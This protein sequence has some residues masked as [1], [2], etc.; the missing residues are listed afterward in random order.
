MK[1]TTKQLV[2]DAMLAAM[3]AVLGYVALDLD[4]IKI[5]FESLPV[6]L[7]ALMFGPLDGLLIGFVGT[8]VYQLLRYGV[9]VTTLLWMLP[10]MLCGLLVGLYAK[11]RDFK[12]TIGQLILI[13]ALG[14]LLIF[15]LNT[16]NIYI[17]AYI[18]TERKGYELLL[19]V[20]GN[21]FLRFIVC[22]VKSAVFPFLLRPLISAVKRVTGEK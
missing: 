6:L 7:G 12:L 10:Y 15:V 9:S 14:E 2:T 20:F 13:V 19:Y 21:T 1:I 5:T 11:K 17:D 22:V 8:G 4:N 3:C 16:G 18:Y